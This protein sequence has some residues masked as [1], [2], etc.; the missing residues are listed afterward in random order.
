LGKKLTSRGELGDD[1]ALLLRV[2]LT[3]HLGVGVERGAL[4]DNLDALFWE[5]DG[6]DLRVHAEAIEELWA[7]LAFFGVTGADQD[8][9]G[10]VLDGDTFALYGVPAGCGGVK[11]NIH[12]VVVQKVHLVDV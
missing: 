5:L 8:E 9:P 1:V 2:L 4:L 6:F 12:Q 11:E 3:E 10:G 7:E